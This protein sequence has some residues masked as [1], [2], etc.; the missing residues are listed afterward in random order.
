MERIRVE[1]MVKALK[2]DSVVQVAIP[3]G[4]IQIQATGS[5][6]SGPVTVFG[7]N[8]NNAS[9]VGCLG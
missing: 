8:I 3:I 1:E 9:G 4:G 5:S 2:L 6:P 7:Y